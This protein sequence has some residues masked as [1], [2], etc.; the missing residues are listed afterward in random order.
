MIADV[1]RPGFG[2]LQSRNSQE[3]VEMSANTPIDRPELTIIGRICTPWTKAEDCPRNAMETDVAC[4]VEVDAPYRDGLKSLETCSHAILLTWFDRAPRDVITLTPPND[5][6]AHGVFA[7]RAPGRPNP[8]G[9]TVVNIVRVEPDGLVV[10]HVDCLD[11]TPLIDIK[12]YFASVDSKP[13][14]RVGWHE[15]RANPLPPRR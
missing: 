14:A 11:G 10:R 3:S 8:I 7:L 2:P 13:D 15:M 4:R 12:P 1:S 5:T 9:L 6:A